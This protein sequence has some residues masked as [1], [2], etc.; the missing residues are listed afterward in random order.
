MSTITIHRALELIKKHT[1]KVEDSKKADLIAIVKGSTKVPQSKA[2]KSKEELQIYLQGNQDSF[3]VS[4]ELIAQL[5]EK[6][7]Q[8][9]LETKVNYLGK[10]VSITKLLAIKE[11]LTLR[12][13]RLAYLRSQL[14]TITDKVQTTNDKVLQDI[15]AL[16]SEDSVK[17]RKD[18]FTM[19][20]ELS[21]I[22]SKDGVSPA[23]LV[24]D[25]ALEV[26]TLGYEVNSLL[27]ESNIKTEIDIEE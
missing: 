8:S 20:D 5:K 9:N 16:A 18:T 22:T 11:T 19:Y 23:K 7:A 2:F 12:K 14:A 10:E 27:S 3:F 26:E 13:Q 15:N 1:K 17:S 4:L 6:I 25:L 24:E 21:L